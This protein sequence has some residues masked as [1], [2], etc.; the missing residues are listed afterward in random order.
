[1][2]EVLGGRRER[3]PG[4]ERRVDTGD[5]GGAGGPKSRHE[6]WLDWG[7]REGHHQE[8]PLSRLRLT[9]Q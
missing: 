9:M 3:E 2:A 5:V 7:M 4:L 8:S 1:M 6:R